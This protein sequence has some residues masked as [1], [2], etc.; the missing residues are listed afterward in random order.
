MNA[1]NG[2]NGKIGWRTLIMTGSLVVAL[3]GGA[4]SIIRNQIAVVDT[5]NEAAI[6]G[7][8]RELTA[9][10]DAAA[11][12]RENIRRQAGT[13]GDVVNSLRDTKL[14]ITRFDQLVNRLMTGGE[15]TAKDAALQKQ[16]DIL[17]DRLDKIEARLSHLE[18]QRGR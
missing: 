4:W 6:A 10:R 11:A 2:T 15:I 1:A 13:I 5:R 7:M 17:G 3:T 14:D 16:I 12:D 18:Q 9:L 8:H